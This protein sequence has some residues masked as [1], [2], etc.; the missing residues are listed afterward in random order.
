MTDGGPCCF[1]SPYINFV[2]PKTR[3]RDPQTLTGEEWHL[4]AKGSKNGL[5]G[6]LKLVLDVESF[7]FVNSGKTTIGF[8]LGFTDH[9]DKSVI[10]Q[11]GYYISPGT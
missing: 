5:I 4:Q 3:D 11:D 10:K 2:D 6:G 1:I 8:R 9:R 7:D